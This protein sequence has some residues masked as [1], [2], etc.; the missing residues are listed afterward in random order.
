MGASTTSWPARYGQIQSRFAGELPWNSPAYHRA[1]IPGAGAIGTARSIAKLYSSLDRL[2]S[3][4]ALELGASELERRHEPLFDEP[5]SFGA[6]FE[7]QSEQKLF[8]PPPGA[9]GHTGAGGSVHGRW[10]NERIGL[11]Y[12]MNL[13]QDDCPHGDPRPKALLD[14]VYQC[15]ASP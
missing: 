13:M 1:E 3:P 10:P 8:G 14:A 11:S 9:F 5:Q 12:A 6:G 2:L 4:E 7:L 15:V